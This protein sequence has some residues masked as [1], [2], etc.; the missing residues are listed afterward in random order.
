MNTEYHV[1]ISSGSDLNDGSRTAPFRTISKAAETAE[2]G[3]RVVVHEGVYREWVKPAHSG[4]SS[5]TRI[6]Y[7]AAEG[8]K[9]VI[10]GSEVID[11]WSRNSDGV[12]QT[13]VSNDMFGDY[14]PYSVRIDGDWFVRPEEYP[15]HTGQVYFDGKG[16]LEAHSYEHLL[17]TAET[18]YAIVDEAENTTAIYANFGDND[19]CSATVEINVRRSCFYPEKTGINYIR[20]VCQPLLV[21]DIAD[22]IPFNIVLRI[23]Y[24]CLIRWCQ[25]IYQSPQCCN[26]FLPKSFLIALY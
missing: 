7:E 16:Y 19:P 6:V 13:T 9:A 20:I 23:R 17:E 5:T 8:E 11:D 14:N 24:F 15:L 12:W 3:D 26:I 1:S 22:F 10:K 21:V 4:H 2:L 18:W 25:I